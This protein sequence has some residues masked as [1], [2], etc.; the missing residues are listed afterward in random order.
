M[1]SIFGVS[2][3]LYFISILYSYNHSA[4][5][6]FQNAVFQ[7]A[8]DKD[9]DSIFTTVMKIWNLIFTGRL[10]S[11]S[12]STIRGLNFTHFALV[13]V[14]ICASVYFKTLEDQTSD[15]PDLDPDKI[16]ELKTISKFPKQAA[17]KIALKILLSAMPLFEIS[18]EEHRQKILLIND[19]RQ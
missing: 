5:F 18:E 14:Y 6:Q 13:C 2:I 11:T 8:D 17:G 1:L 9:R 16:S 10:F 4:Y 12:Q 19:Q 7:S 3:V 15:D